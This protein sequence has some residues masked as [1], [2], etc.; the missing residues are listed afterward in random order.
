MRKYLAV[1]L[2]FIIAFSISSQEKPVITVLDFSINNVSKSDMKSIISL[3]SSALFRTG[4]YTVIDVSQRDQILKELQFSLSGCSDE[5]CQ[6]EIG[7]ML[8]AE[9]II[10]GDIGN[11]G[12]RFILTSKILETETG[13]TLKTSD[14]IYKDLDEL[15]D[16]IFLFT[17]RLTAFE[18][19]VVSTNT[20]V[21]TAKG[22][23]TNPSGSEP[24]AV[25][26]D[27]VQVNESSVSEESSLG[28]LSD[29]E[30]SGDNTNTGKQDQEIIPLEK[31]TE[32]V[33]N[34]KKIAAYSS[35]GIGIAATLAGGYLFYDAVEFYNN[36]VDPA[37][38]NYLSATTDF[39]TYWT[40]YTAYQDDL[41][42]KAIIASAVSGGG[43][44][45]IGLGVTL[46]LLPEKVKEST[47]VAFYINPAKGISAL[48]FKYS[49]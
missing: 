27:A 30:A 35:L 23:E 39:D 49:F 19:A 36:S 26:Q 40:T 32:K 48:A 45:F 34:A 25:E 14:G 16:D 11:V 44:L 10:V 38:Q 8:S 6:L 13:K 29:N 4:K 15:V 28:D 42:T 12:N 43:L 2:L 18:P 1:C 20:S 22:N 3:F 33:V 21:S 41:K 17:D 31:R 5:S 47:D 46:F 9:Q 24:V 37:Y 7:K